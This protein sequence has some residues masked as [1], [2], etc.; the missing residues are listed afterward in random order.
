MTSEMAITRKLHSSDVTV[1]MGD[2]SFAKILLQ[3]SEILM[4]FVWR[5]KNNRSDTRKG[6]QNATLNGFPGLVLSWKDILVDNFFLNLNQ[7]TKTGCV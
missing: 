2:D 7:M 6:W 3:S 5:E 1:L 4:I